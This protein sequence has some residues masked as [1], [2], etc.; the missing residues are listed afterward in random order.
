M[1]S[2]N[3][4]FDKL[5]IRADALVTVGGQL[6]GQSFPFGSI[7]R[8]LSLARAYGAT[9]ELRIDP[10][11]LDPD[12]LRLLAEL[13]P[14]NDLLQKAV[15]KASRRKRLSMKQDQSREL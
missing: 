4:P 9:V 6:D 1:I 5:I 3:I 8:V 12:T 7:M 11:A 14:D 13:F 2:K 15:Q 10:E